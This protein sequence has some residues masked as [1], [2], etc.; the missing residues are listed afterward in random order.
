MIRCCNSGKRGVVPK[1]LTPEYAAPEVLASFLSKFRKVGRQ[2]SMVKGPVADCFSAGIVLYQMLTGYVPFSLHNTDL[3][4]IKVPKHVPGKAR[5]Q[6]QMAAAV[7]EQHMS[8][9]YQHMLG[10]PCMNTCICCRRSCITACGLYTALHV[11]AHASLTEISETPCWI[12]HSA[13]VND[14]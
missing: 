7:L 2:C 5:V 1:G 6:W 4:Q 11:A 8:W 9:V 14:A 13:A 12:N 10:H 3:F